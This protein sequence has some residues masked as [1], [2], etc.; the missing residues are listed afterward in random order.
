MAA[1]IPTNEPEVIFAGDTLKFDKTLADYP[2]SGGWSLIYYLVNEEQ[3]YNF[4]SSANGSDHRVNIAKGTTADYVPGVYQFTGYAV[5]TTER[6]KVFGSVSIEIKPNPANGEASETRSQARRTLD[7][8]NN[9]LEA[10]AGN[11]VLNSDVETARFERIPHS[12]LL[13][14]K[15]YYEVKVA[16]ENA[17][18]SGVNKR[19]IFVRFTR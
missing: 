5:S 17:T 1:E 15:D 14:L 9:V 6:T 10:R 4:T 18:A 13:K 19:N 7:A 2:A 12:E 3:N 11:T 8:I 16:S